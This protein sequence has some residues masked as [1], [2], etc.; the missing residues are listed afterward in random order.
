MELWK[1]CVVTRS[2]A[3]CLELGI[4]RVSHKNVSHFEH[5]LRFHEPCPCT[6]CH[7]VINTRET[8]LLERLQHARGI[9]QDDLVYS[10][11][12]NGRATTLT[13]TRGNVPVCGPRKPMQDEHRKAQLL[14]L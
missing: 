14:R 5:E 2:V 8:I 6:F 12:H 9:I 11:A 7:C 3:D 10:L 4:C 13:R 1:D